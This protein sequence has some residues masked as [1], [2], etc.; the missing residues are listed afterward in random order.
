MPWRRDDPYLKVVAYANLSICV[1]A[2]LALIWDPAAYLVLAA[3]LFMVV[4]VARIMRRDL[5]TTN[6]YTRRSKTLMLAV[7]V[8][9]GTVDPA[10]LTAEQREDI[11]VERARYQLRDQ[12]PS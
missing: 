1:T 6:E 11:A 9:D 3:I 5:S 4:A 2:I 12:G 10:T 7:R 8:Q